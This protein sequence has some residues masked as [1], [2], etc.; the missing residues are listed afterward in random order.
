MKVKCEIKVSL[1]VVGILLPILK[2]LSPQ[3]CK[4]KAELEAVVCIAPLSSSIYCRKTEIC[5]SS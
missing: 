1:K 2:Q 3:K 4:S 5:Q